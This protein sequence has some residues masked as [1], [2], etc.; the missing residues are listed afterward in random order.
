MG[1]RQAHTQKARVTPA[2]L[3]KKNNIKAYWVINK[4][5][6]LQ[7]WYEPSSFKPGIRHLCSTHSN[8]LSSWNSGSDAPHEQ[9]AGPVE[10]PRPGGVIFGFLFLFVV[11]FRILL[12]FPLFIIIRYEK[13]MFKKQKTTKKELTL[14]ISL[15]TFNLLFLFII[16]VFPLFLLHRF[17][18]AVWIRVRVRIRVT[19]R[20]TGFIVAVSA[21]L[22]LSSRLKKRKWEQ[23]G[24]SV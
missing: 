6:V 13:K 4:D 1:V 23:W 17:L 2:E 8:N 16:L 12:W 11:Y 7:W 24:H 21:A 9:G 14:G 19:L 15:L 18:R 3:R 20:G 22:P 10:R 5:S